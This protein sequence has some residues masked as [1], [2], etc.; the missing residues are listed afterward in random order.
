VNNAALRLLDFP[1]AYTMNFKMENIQIQEVL[2]ANQIPD[3]TYGT[4]MLTLD[5]EGKGITLPNLKT[6]L[7]SRGEFSIRDGKRIATDG[8]LLDRIYLAL[9]NPILLNLLPELATKIQQA[10]AAQ[11]TKK[12]THIEDC[13]VAFNVTQGTATL[14]QCKVGTPDYLFQ[15]EGQ[16][17]P[18]EDK[19]DLK[20]KF[21]FSEKATLELTG[22]KDLSDRLPYENKGILIPLTL[23]GSMSKPKVIPDLKVILKK[24]AGG[25]MQNALQNLLGAKKKEGAVTDTE[26]KKSGLSGLLGK[27]G[28]KKLSGLLGNL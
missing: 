23:T 22:Q 17:Y 14:T 11:G 9:D 12:E 4:L 19:I 20:A 28:K 26:T 16:A 1:L 7:S 2:K 24:I 25:Q 13:V 15:A 21:N 6:N 18:F 10:K 5:A 8:T 27:D 3:E